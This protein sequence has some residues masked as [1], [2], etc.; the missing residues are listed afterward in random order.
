MKKKGEKYFVLADGLNSFP[1]KWVKRMNF[2]K[3]RIGPARG[4]LGGLGWAVSSRKQGEASQ[5][6]EVSKGN[7]NQSPQMHQQSQ[8]A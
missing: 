8:R 3:R 4:Q 6:Q 2:P 1:G 5:E 7:P